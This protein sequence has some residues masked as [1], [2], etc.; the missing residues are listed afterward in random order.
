MNYAKADRTSLEIALMM[1]A[2]KESVARDTQANQR[3]VDE[4]LS[5]MNAGAHGLQQ[6][7]EQQ[8]SVVSRLMDQLSMKL[9]REE[10][11]A[12]EESMKAAKSSGENVAEMIL[13]KVCPVTMF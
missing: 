3:A 11:K 5:T 4:A 7:L 2:D 8:E 13:S 12:L 6:L 1:K 9:D 10:L